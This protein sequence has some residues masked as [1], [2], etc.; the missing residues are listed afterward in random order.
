MGRNS[1]SREFVES[2]REVNGLLIYF[3]SK[4][5]VYVEERATGRKLLFHRWFETKPGFYMNNWRKFVWNLKYVNRLTVNKILIS[6][7]VYGIEAQ[8]ARSMPTPSVNAKVFP[9]RRKR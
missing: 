9:E 6:A 4:E 8:S 2:V 5:T 3:N 7:S 1:V